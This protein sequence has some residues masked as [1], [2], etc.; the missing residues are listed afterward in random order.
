MP[1]LPGF[2]V[3]MKRELALPNETTSQFIA[4]LKELTDADKEW[5]W[6]ALQAAGIPCKRPGER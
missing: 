1:D 6:E 5:Y 4:H 3:T 2:M